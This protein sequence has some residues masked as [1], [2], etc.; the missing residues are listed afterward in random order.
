[1]KKI[2]HLACALLCLLLAFQASAQ[3]RSRSAQ[4]SKKEPLTFK[5]RLW[6]GANL[7][8]GGGLGFGGSGSFGLGLAP[9]VGYKIIEQI[10][11]GPRLSASLQTYK[12]A[13]YKATTLFD[14]GLS[15]FVRGRVFRGLFLQGEVGA[16]WNQQLADPVGNRFTKVTTQRPN[17]VVG[18][19]WN[20]ARGGFSTEIGAFY[21]FSV[22]NDLYTSNSPWEFRFG[23]TWKY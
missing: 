23:F 18:A 6:Y 12:Q 2:S 11:V 15:G 17:Q 8:L 1:M 5:E 10:S 9:M 14:T 4:K 7:Q 22:A 19:G 3:V 13:G 21:N 20:N 16:Q